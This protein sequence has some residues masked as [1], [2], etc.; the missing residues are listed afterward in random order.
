MTPFSPK[1]P[2]ISF[3]ALG[4]CPSKRRQSADNELNAQLPRVVTILAAR[5]LLGNRATEGPAG[6]PDRRRGGAGCGCTDRRRDW[7]W[8]LGRRRRRRR[9]LTPAPAAAAAPG[10]GVTGRAARDCTGAAAAPDARR[11]ALGYPPSLNGGVDVLSAEQAT[12][13]WTA[14]IGETLISIQ[15]GHWSCHRCASLTNGELNLWKSTFPGRLGT[16]T[17]KCDVLTCWSTLE[18]EA[19]I[20]IPQMFSAGGALHWD[21]PH[22]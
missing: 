19:A 12:S 8:R 4:L 18:M 14:A 2:S 3:S 1:R 7:Q 21:F 13:V 20:T 9:P 5:G 15:D 10:D 17:P 6:D 16:L 22:P 11:A